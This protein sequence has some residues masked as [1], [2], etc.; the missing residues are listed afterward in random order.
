[1]AAVYVLLGGIPVRLGDGA[2]YGWMVAAAGDTINSAKL[3]LLCARL[4]NR[5]D[6]DSG[7]RLL[8]GGRDPPQ[9]A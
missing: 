8:A 1:M 7:P 5:P 3:R 4:N 9:L 2:G 6:D